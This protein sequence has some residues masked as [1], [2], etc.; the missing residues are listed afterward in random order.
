MSDF[1]SAGFRPGRS[2]GTLLRL[3][4]KRD[5]VS[6][7]LYGTDRGRELAVTV[8]RLS[9]VRRLA[10]ALQLGQTAYTAGDDALQ[11]MCEWMA[12]H[13]VPVRVTP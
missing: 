6:A 3:C 1:P 2:Q 13:G 5:S 12:A 4:V 7:A 11:A 8:C 9:D 10:G